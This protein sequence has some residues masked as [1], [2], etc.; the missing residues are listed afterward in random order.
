MRLP[1]GQRARGIAAESVFRALDH[2]RL[3]VL[4]AV[5]SGAASKRTLEVPKKFTLLRVFAF[6]R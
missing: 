5:K 2:I 3:C 6:A 4:A 1:P